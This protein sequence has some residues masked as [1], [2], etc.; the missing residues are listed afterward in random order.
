MQRN[1]TANTHR[2]LRALAIISTNTKWGQGGGCPLITVCSLIRS[3]T[4]HGIR[5]IEITIGKWVRETP[6]KTADRSRWRIIVKTSSLAEILNK[7]LKLRIKYSTWLSKRQTADIA[8]SLLYNMMIPIP[9]SV[10][11]LDGEIVINSTDNMPKTNLAEETG[12]A[13][14]MYLCTVFDLISEQSA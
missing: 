8:H 6:V 10:S 3:N 2:S 7:V 13:L 14:A 5:K 9:I 1:K 4:V 12:F 11:M